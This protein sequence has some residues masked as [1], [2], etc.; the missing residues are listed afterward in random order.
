MAPRGRRLRRLD[1][2]VVN[3]H[4][5]LFVP[6][7]CSCLWTRRPDDLR[8]AFTLVPE[9]LRTDDEAE[10]LSDYGPALGR[11]FRALKLWAVIRCFGRSGLQARI[12]EGMRLAQMFARW[13][14]ETPGWEL[15]APQMFSLVCFRMDGTDAQNEALLSR[16][17]DTGELFISHTRLHD[18]YVLRL[19][20]GHARTTEADVARA[21]DVI[22]AQADAVVRGA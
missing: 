14:G 5:W 16:V 12:R 21:W 4:K 7:D 9:Y 3:P 20:I 15:A 6:M 19:A 22:R 10:S 11:R 8:R 13:V 2:L 18:R 1:S 17:N